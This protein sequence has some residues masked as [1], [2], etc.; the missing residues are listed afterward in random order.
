MEFPRPKNIT[1]V[2]SL[3]GLLEQVSYSFSKTHALA[4]FR[5]LLSSKEDFKWDD[6]LQLAFE[7]MKREIT[8][9]LYEGV[10]TFVMGKITALVTDFSK[11]GVG[12]LLLQKHCKCSG[13]ELK[14]CISG[15][16]V[17]C[18]GSRFCLKAEQRYSAI[19]G[20]L[21]GISWALEKT[22]MWTLGNPSLHI[23]TDHKPI[24]DLLTNKNL[25]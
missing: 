21:M 6:K 14:C 20:E 11:T 13:I 19:E 15:W 3:F 23:F 25:D 4:P 17:I 24:I 7:S 22:K 10:K 2:R 8:D 12:Y 5:H 16:K 1:G 18:V 9:Q